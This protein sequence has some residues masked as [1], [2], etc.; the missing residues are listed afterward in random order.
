[1]FPL[2]HIWF[3]EKVLG[4]MNNL[5]VLGAVFPDIVI[6][7]CLKYDNTHNVGFGIY[8]HFKKTNP[9]FMDFVKSMLT[10]TVNPNGLDYYSDEA[11]LNGYKGYCFQKGMEIE[12][13]VIDACNIPEEYGLWKAHNFIEMGVELN[14]ADSEPKL[15]QILH[16]SF[17]DKDLI[18]KI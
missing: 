8:E 18:T 4:Y 14:I 10:H 2:T 16:N 15:S 13:E 17:C 1:M 11:Y 6:T 9:S 3:S 12:K 7:K 5:T